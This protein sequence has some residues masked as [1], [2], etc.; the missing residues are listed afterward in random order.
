MRIYCNYWFWYIQVNYWLISL[1]FLSFSILSLH[2]YTEAIFCHPCEGYHHI[3]HYSLA[4]FARTHFCEARMDQV[5]N[6]V[7]LRTH[8]D[9]WELELSY[10]IRECVY[11]VAPHHM[12]RSSWHEYHDPRG[13]IL[14]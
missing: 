5:R 10:R 3:F 6:R 9:S 13:R 7:D 1:H 8:H 2:A 12:N 4:C 14:G 11:R